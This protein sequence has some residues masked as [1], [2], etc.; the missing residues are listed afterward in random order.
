VQKQK[1]WCV[2]A[3]TRPGATLVDPMFIEELE[4]EKVV[5]L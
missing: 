2:G 4:E 5:E 3:Q 1:N